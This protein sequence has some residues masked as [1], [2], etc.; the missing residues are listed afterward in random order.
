MPT[1]W[2]KPGPITKV[3]PKLPETE[4]ITE[5]PKPKPETSPYIK[6]QREDG[7]PD[8]SGNRAK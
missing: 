4:P 5:W 8:E 6:R 3:G 1:K 7:N 2:P